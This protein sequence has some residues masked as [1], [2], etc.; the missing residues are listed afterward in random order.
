MSFTDE[1]YYYDE[2]PVDENI[3][4]TQDG[5]EIAIPDLDDNHLLNILNMLDK[6]QTAREYAADSIEDMF[7]D[8]DDFYRSEPERH[9]QHSRLLTERKRRK[10]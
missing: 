7:G 2:D 6:I 5:K 4:R 9:P 8:H 3:W 1:G 10:L